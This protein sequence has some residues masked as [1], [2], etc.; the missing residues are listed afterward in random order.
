M[1]IKKG[2]LFNFCIFRGTSSFSFHQD[3]SKENDEMKCK[4][5]KRES[6]P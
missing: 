2:N 5:E 1:F 4:H 6:K 3:R